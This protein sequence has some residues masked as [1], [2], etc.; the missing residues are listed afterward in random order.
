M[1][2]CKISFLNEVVTSE[3]EPEMEIHQESPT[4]IRTQQ[5]FDALLKEVQADY[6]LIN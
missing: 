2:K 3:S 1:N 6:S 4:K 5:E